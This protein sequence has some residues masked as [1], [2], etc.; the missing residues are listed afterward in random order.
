MIELIPIGNKT[1]EGLFVLE[2]DGKQWMLLGDSLSNV[3]AR[4]LCK[5]TGH[6]YVKIKV[7]I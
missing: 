1:N 6:G 3:T 4:T 2:H 7:I 5:L